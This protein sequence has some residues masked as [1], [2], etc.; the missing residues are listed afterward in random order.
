VADERLMC[1]EPGQEVE[2]TRLPEGIL[3]LPGSGE[4]YYITPTHLRKVALPAA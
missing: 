1:F 3:A 2:I 4:V